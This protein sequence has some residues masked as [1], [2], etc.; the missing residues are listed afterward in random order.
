MVWWAKGAD[1]T[2]SNSA[3][4]HPVYRNVSFL[5]VPVIAHNFM[6]DFHFCSFLN[7]LIVYLSSTSFHLLSHF[8][9]FLKHDSYS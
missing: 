1:R 5:V 7:G 8:K 2:D 3:S 4:S 6:D 9:D